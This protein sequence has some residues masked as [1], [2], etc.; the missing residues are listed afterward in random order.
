[1]SG[2]DDIA[3]RARSSSETWAATDPATRAGVLTALADALRGSGERLT[4]IAGAETGLS[5]TRLSGELERTAVQ[6]DMFASV[7]RAGAFLDVRID[8]RDDRFALG[9]RPDLRR[10]RIPVGPV[11]VFAAGNF[12][13][14]FSVL[15]GDT[16]SALAAGCAVIVKGHSGHP[17]LASAVTELARSVL[18]DEGMP[19]DVLQLITGQEAGVAM[20]RHPF[21]AASSFTGS[22]RVGAMLAGI[23]AS[24][25]DPIPFYG[26]LGSVNP[27][28]V[29]PRAAAERA[30]SIAA[31]YLASV[32]GS[33]GQLCTKPGFLFVPSGSEVTERIGEAVIDESPHRL[34]TPGIAESFEQRRSAILG[35]PV[36]VVRPGG[37]E[38]D[39]SGEAWATPT[40]VATTTHDLSAHAKALAEEA[41]GPLSI[42]VE[43]DR[44]EDLVGIASAVLGGNLT[45]TVHLAEG[46]AEDASRL[47]RWLEAHSGRVVINGWPTG[48]AVT[49]A[50]QHGGPWP[51]STNA[52]TTSVGTAAVD[53][54]T[55]PVVYQDTPEE[56]LPLPLRDDNPWGVPQT[57][58]RAGESLTWGGRT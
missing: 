11:L 26:E 3:A 12:P 41:F 44:P 47:V 9:I 31:G 6:L 39:A 2:I 8:E 57:R 23:A 28:F 53:R 40:I 7:A 51:A 46:D 22:V 13:F 48:V 25:P 42:V 50:M 56:L 21:V 58:S 45:G 33:A 17:R 19:S 36:R 30:E 34:L 38:R 29:M 27:A 14:A 37:L 54:F 4:A 20:L 55:R 35:S 49:P 52:G 16:A 43:Y 15:G 32:G 1:M 18:A 24:R 5:E 10:Y